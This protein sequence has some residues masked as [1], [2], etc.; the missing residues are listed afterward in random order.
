MSSSIDNKYVIFK[1][2]NEFYGI[3]I[4]R[5]TSIEKIQKS[6]RIP[7]SPNHLK[8]VINLRGEVIPLIDLRQKLNMETKEIDHNSR[9]IIVFDEEVV[10]GLI[11]DSSSEVIEINKNS[12]DNIPTS[13]ENN[14][15]SYISGIGK[16]DNRLIILLELSKLL[17]N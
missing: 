5:V 10:A 2:N 17:E 13:A 12:I 9:V 16:Q 4:E 7:N 6:T 14:S 11:V 15:L 1:L 3:P 8:G